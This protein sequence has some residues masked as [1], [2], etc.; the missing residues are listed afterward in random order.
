MTQVSPQKKCW[1]KPEFKRLG[2]IKDV[3]AGG[4]LVQQG[5]SGNFS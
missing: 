4:G 5:S 3:A 2:Q 1:T